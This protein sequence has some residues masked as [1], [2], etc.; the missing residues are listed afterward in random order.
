M[1]TYCKLAWANN[2]Y[3][4]KYIIYKEDYNAPVRENF[5]VGNDRLD[6]IDNS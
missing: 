6:S 2:F 3:K 1:R 4:E 5:H